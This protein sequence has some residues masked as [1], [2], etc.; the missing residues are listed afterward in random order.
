M[1]WLQLRF[2][3]DKIAIWLQFDRNSISRRVPKMQLTTSSQ[4]LEMTSV[5]KAAHSRRSQSHVEVELYM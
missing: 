5:V 2:H 1:R 4:S 3:R